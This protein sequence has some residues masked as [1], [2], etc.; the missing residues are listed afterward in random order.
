MTTSK[1]ARSAMGAHACASKALTDYQA[2]ERGMA[3]P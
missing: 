2:T 1:N 3:T